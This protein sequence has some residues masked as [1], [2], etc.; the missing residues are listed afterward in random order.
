MLERIRY[1]VNLLL[2]QLLLMFGNER[3]RGVQIGPKAGFDRSG[4]SN[5][6]QVSSARR[7]ACGSQLHSGASISKESEN[8]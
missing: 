2:K 6:T 8:T 7:G 1:P 5:S 4:R 3:R